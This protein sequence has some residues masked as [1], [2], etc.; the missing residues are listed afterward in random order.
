[1]VQMGTKRKV[2]DN[3]GVRE[4]RCIRILEGRKKEGGVGRKV[5][6]VVT[7]R[8][9]GTKW[10]RGIRVKGVRVRRKKER[11]RKNGMWVSGEENG[12]GLRNA[13][14]EPLGNRVGGVLPYELRGKGYGKVLARSVYVV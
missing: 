3:S 4:V 14:G 11:K 6:G 7:K 1:M 10:K 12:R 2:V 9:T 5:V 13:K 8:R